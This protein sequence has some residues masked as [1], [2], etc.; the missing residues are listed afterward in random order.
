VTMHCPATP[1]T[2]GM[3]N[4]GFFAKMKKASFS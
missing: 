3:V 4:R 2:R 1:E